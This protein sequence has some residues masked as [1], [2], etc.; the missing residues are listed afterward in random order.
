[1]L[2]GTLPSSAS[3]ASLAA[4][5]AHAASHTHVDYVLLAEFDIDQGSILKH[6]YPHDTGTD[7]HL[8]AEH[9]LPDGAHDRPEDW[10]VFYLNQVPA[11]TVRDAKGKGKALDQDG[12]NGTGATNDADG[13]LLYVMSLVRTKKDATVRRGALVKALAVATRNPYI[14]IF[15]PILLLA[16]EDYFNNPSL[17]VLANLYESLNAMDTSA[18]PFLTAD[19][20]IVLRTSDRKDLFEHKFVEAAARVRRSDSGRSATAI[21]SDAASLA[22]RASAGEE[23]SGAAE[24]LEDGLSSRGA[25]TDDLHHQHP[26]HGVR[27][28]PSSDSLSSLGHTPSIGTAASASRDDLPSTGR[29]SSRATTFTVASSTDEARSSWSQQPPVPPLPRAAAGRGA[30]AAGAQA[31]AG[32]PKDTHFF[33]TRVVYNGVTL[34]VKIPLATFPS[35]VGDYSLI[36]LIQTFSSPSS[37]VPGPLHPHLHTSGASTPALIV[38]FNALLTNQRVVFLGHGQPAARVAEL[39]LAACALVSGCGSVLQGGIEER[40]FPY[41][42]L[43]NLDNLENVDGYIAGVC[44]PAFADRPS[45]W[46]VLCNLETGRITVSKELKLPSSPSAGTASTGTFGRGAGTLRGEFASWA[47]GGAGGTGGRGGA[48]AGGTDAVDEMGQLAGSAAA[49]GGGGSG[50]TGKGGSESHDVAFMDEILHAIQAH[51]GESVIRARLTDYVA[52]FVRLASRYEEET[53]STTSIGFPS[54]PCAHGSLGSGIVFGDEGAGQREVLGNAARIEAWMRTKSYKVY[55]QTFRQSLHDSP[56]RGFDLTHQIMRLRLSRQLPPAETRLIFQTLAQSVRTD[57]QVV[58]LLAQLPSHFGGLLPLAFGFFHPAP[59]VRHH[60]LELFDTISSHP[61]GSK[62]VSTL[63]AF[64]RLAY[65][66]LA[67][68]REASAA[69]A[70]AR[71]Q[72]A[73]AGAGS[74]REREST[75]TLHVGPGAGGPPLPLKE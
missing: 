14:Q 17:S 64:H 28:A 50:G 70:V 69:A 36:K 68:E 15:K 25:T 18:L 9:M 38:L 57:E 23:G 29:S 33:E 1:M 65:A 71:E 61:T 24:V 51:Y 2:A 5:H 22:A 46:D 63:N 66:R 49:G 60:T 45:W 37:L 10:T 42:N 26:L 6:Q 74:G 48:G 4:A 59:E 32:R 35:E 16:L 52:R 58:T 73:G 55:Q 53:T 44:N 19:E 54:A 13:G 39:V 3:T 11:L 31:M 27:P 67:R 41:T 75:I 47:P 7:E 21:D 56:V 43:S 12:D 20:R 40:A 62:F 72:H 8:L 34:P 30:G